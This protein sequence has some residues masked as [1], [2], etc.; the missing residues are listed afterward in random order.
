MTNIY[1]ELKTENIF[2]N[3]ETGRL[4]LCTR[5]DQHYMGVIDT[6]INQKLDWAPYRY[7]SKEFVL[8]DIE[9]MLGKY[10]AYKNVDR[11]VGMATTRDDVRNE[12]YR[13]ALA[14]FKYALICTRDLEEHDAEGVKNTFIAAANTGN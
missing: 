7:E 13:L 9:K 3:F 2:D 5:I 12:I 14:D 8:G 1:R 11:L 6:I 10:D 4:Y